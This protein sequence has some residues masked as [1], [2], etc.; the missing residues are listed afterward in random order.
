ME[1]NLE[2]TNESYESNLEENYENI[3][4]ETEKR[5]NDI[6]RDKDNTIVFDKIN[7]TSDNE[8]IN[9]VR[10]EAK[11]NIDAGKKLIEDINCLISKQQ[12][13]A[14]IAGNLGAVYSAL[15]NAFEMR[16]NAERLL[17][18]LEEISLKLEA[19]IERGNSTDVEKK[20]E[21]ISNVS[22][23]ISTLIN[24]LNNPK[25]VSQNSNKMT[26]FDELSII[27]ENE[28]KRRIAEEIRNICGEAELKKLK[29]DLELQEEKN[30]MNS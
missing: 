26:R 4:K 22:I 17:S 13:H 1:K 11:E 29:D 14:R 27:E 9:R 23:Q 10:T 24:Y 8:L 18:L 20:L 3:I 5:I 25:I 7:T 28:L 15:N 2:G 16:E 30:L 21:N 12:N 6:L 19:I